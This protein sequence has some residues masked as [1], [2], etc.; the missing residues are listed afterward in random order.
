MK[1]FNG[2]N[3][4]KVKKNQIV[5]NLCEKKY[6]YKLLNLSKGKVYQSSNLNI[7]SI[8]LMNSPSKNSIIKINNKEIN[9]SKFKFFTFNLKKIKI[10]SNSKITI[11]LAGLKKKVKF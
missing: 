11:G 4:G 1:K 3:I 7:G 5:Q 10:E 8:A 6:I 2:I 9:L